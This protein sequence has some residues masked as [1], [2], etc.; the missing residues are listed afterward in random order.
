[1]EDAESE[2]W[3]VQSVALELAAELVQSQHVGVVGIEYVCTGV[4][5]L[6]FS[7]TL[8]GEKLLKIGIWGR[9]T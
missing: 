1:M 8:V 4:N 6:P 2:E 5:K 7:S 9:I 3:C